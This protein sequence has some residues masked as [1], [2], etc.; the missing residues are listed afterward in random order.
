MPATDPSVFPE[1]PP[2]VAEWEDL[3]VRLEIMPR[4]LRNTLGD[5]EPETERLRGVFQEM[6]EREA[7]V[8]GWLEQAAG[9]GSPRPALVPDPDAEWLYRR[10]A[11]L[12]ARNF[13]MVQRR[14]LDVWDWAGPGPA[15]GTV[16]VYQLFIWLLQRDADALAAARG[17][18]AGPA[19]C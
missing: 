5:A 7:W 12:R 14:G 19:A 10:F 11:S 3:L 15:G 4:A 8:G 13:A 16:S 6:V 1:R 2:A 17:A 9:Y 18:L